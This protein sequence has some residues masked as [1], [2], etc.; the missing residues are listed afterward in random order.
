VPAG[1]DLDL[2][3]QLTVVPAPGVAVR[4]DDLAELGVALEQ[5]ELDDGVR[6][7]DGETGCFQ[8]LALLLRVQE[9][10]PADGPA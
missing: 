4:V 9:L 7:G 1:G 2:R 6:P 5:R 8:R 3:P 10:R